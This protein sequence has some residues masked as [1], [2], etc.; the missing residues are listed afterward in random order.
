MLLVYGTKLTE[1]IILLKGLSTPS[2]LIETMAFGL[3]QRPCII[4][5]MHSYTFPM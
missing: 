5:T 1:S 3:D 2:D 4:E